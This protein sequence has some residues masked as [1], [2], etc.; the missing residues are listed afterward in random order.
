VIAVS[1]TRVLEPRVGTLGDLAELYG[2][3]GAIGI[4][5]V[6]L[7]LVAYCDITGQ[8]GKVRFVGQTG[9]HLLTLSSSLRERGLQPVC[10]ANTEA[11]RSAVTRPV[12]GQ[13]IH[14][15]TR[16]PLVSNGYAFDFP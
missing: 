12:D 11:H 14:I 13:K 4:C 1:G 7:P 3:A 6:P 16:P 9:K 8:P 15:H 10:Q 2:L 5:P